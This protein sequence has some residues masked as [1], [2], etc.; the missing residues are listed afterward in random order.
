[1]HRRAVPALRHA[2]RIIGVASLTLWGGA[3]EASTPLGQAT[4]ASPAAIG[5]GASEPTCTTTVGGNAYAGIAAGCGANSDVT[6]PTNFQPGLGFNGG[7]AVG[8][9]TT[10]T[11]AN[12]IAIG[13][14][15]QAHGDS[16]IVIG[17]GALGGVAGTNVNNT[18]TIGVD[19]RTTGTNG[20]SIGT[21]ARASDSNTTAVG[22]WAA[23][24]QPSATALGVLSLASGVESTA[25]RLQRESA[26]R[27][28]CLLGSQATAEGGFSVAVGSAA[29]ARSTGASSGSPIA[30]GANANATGVY[31]SANPL[32]PNGSTF[33]AI[34]IGNAATA[35]GQTGTALGL[36][37]F[38][39]EETCGRRRSAARPPLPGR[40]PRRWA[41]SAQASARFVAGPGLRRG[42][43][44]RRQRRAGFERG[45]HRGR[46]YQLRGPCACRATHARRGRK[47]PWAAL[48]RN[49]RSPTWRPAPCPPMP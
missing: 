34:A 39:N 47:Y 11:G 13:S 15:N 17:V 29:T 27:Q 14:S 1:M 24:V 18:T 40:G 37:Q 46:A 42:G 48:A 44:K 3:G 7:I 23:A 16:A 45:N 43:H 25:P 8:A 31:G 6:D 26:V 32:D 21:S 38:R 4:V 35:T 9:G 19:T 41:W 36:D 33:E 12:D 30:I 20:I 2:R 10:T 5:I 49:G 22:L 28:R